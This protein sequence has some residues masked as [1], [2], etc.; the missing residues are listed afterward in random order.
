M[1]RRKTVL[2]LSKTAA[3]Y[4]NHRASASSSPPLAASCTALNKKKAHDVVAKVFN[5]E[6]NNNNTGLGLLAG[7]P[8]VRSADFYTRK[9]NLPE[10]SKM[11]MDYNYIYA[12]ALRDAGG[13][14]I[15]L[16]TNLKKIEKSAVAFMKLGQMWDRAEL[17][18]HLESIASSKGKF[19][20]LLAGKSTGK[21]LIL[22]NLEQDHMEKV[23]VVNLRL[24][25]P[26]ILEGLR[27]VL[28]ERKSYFS[29]SVEKMKSVVVPAVGAAMPSVGAA[30][31]LGIGGVVS[32]VIE[33]LLKDDD[34]ATKTLSVLVN[35]LIKGLGNNVTLIIDEANIA[36]NIKETTKEEKVESTKAALE[37]FTFL[38]KEAQKVIRLFSTFLFLLII[39]I[40]LFQFLVERDPRFK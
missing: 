1:F 15:K 25:G 14:V 18:S 17:K 26:D 11:V 19:A 13:D 23:F 31:P 3:L 6:N 38:T 9:M 4:A 34:P 27:N 22:R 37:L 36:F 2:A 29:K 24:H 30:M 21:S 32:K 12:S 39:I 28:Q 5:E 33:E 16:D 40:F 35:G 20:C 8:D 10:A 7:I